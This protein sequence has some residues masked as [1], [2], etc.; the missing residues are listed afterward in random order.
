MPVASTLHGLSA[1]PNGHPL[2]VG[3]LGMHGNYGPNLLTNEADLIIGCGMRFD[4][5]VTGK[6]ASYA[7]NAKVIHI[8]IDQAEINK[9]VKVDV[10]ICADVKETLVAL[11]PLVQ[12][13]SHSEWRNEFHI[14]QE[15]ENEKVI[16]SDLYPKTPQIRM[17]EVI[18][19]ISEKTN[20]NAVV[21]AD[22]GQHQMMTARYYQFK[23][24]DSFITSG[25]LGTMGFALPATI[26]AKIAA[27][28]RQVIGIVGDGC[29]QMTIQ[30][31]G[32][33]AQE[34]LPVKIVILNNNFLGMV[35]QWQEMFFDRRYSFVELKNPD[36]VAVSKGFGV[37]AERVENRSDLDAALNRMLEAKTAYLLDIRV[38]KESNVFPMVPAGASVS[39][40][41]L[42]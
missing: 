32:T 41:R 6:L 18:R 25:G 26:G 28:D 36:F 22:V 15:K 29:I 21:V 12:K 2:Y 31:L 17:S 16:N 37:N 42:E 34:G 38:E 10:G 19:M 11:M 4:D 7:V 13:R 3:M 39:D 40:V 20:G 30:E 24:P 5:R 33:I 14:C 35:R 8:D 23:E 9:C 1:V 27:P